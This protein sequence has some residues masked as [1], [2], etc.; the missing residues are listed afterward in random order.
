MLWRLC[1]TFLD[2]KAFHYKGTALGIAF[3]PVFHRSTFCIVLL[4]ADFNGL[5]TLEGKGYILAPKLVIGFDISVFLIYRTK[6]PVYHKPVNFKL[7]I[8]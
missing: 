1:Y 7:C 4:P 6:Q 8:I 3:C 2:I 5:F